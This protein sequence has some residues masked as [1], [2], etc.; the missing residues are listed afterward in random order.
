MGRAAKRAESKNEECVQDF[1]AVVEAALKTPGSLEKKREALI[2]GLAEDGMLAARVTRAVGAGRLQ[3]T[4]QDGTLEYSAKI[5]GNLAFKGR[6]A[7]KQDRGSH[8]GIGDVIV[9]RGGLASGKLSPGQTARC[10]EIFEELEVRVPAGF[11]SSRDATVAT[12]AEAAAEAGAGWT[13]DRAAS[14]SEEEGEGE[15]EAVAAR[16]GGGGPPPAT[17]R[18]GGSK[19]VTL[20]TLVVDDI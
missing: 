17:K 16:G 14:A 13:W 6:A 10:G 15:G 5:A 9:V 12:A 8:M 18:G 4:L 3:V 7:T 20:E 1:C 2:S 19:H 11:F